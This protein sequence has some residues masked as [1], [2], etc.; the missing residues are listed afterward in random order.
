MKRDKDPDELGSW[1]H[2]G[3]DC[4]FVNFECKL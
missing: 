1:I 2:E 4:V 3:N